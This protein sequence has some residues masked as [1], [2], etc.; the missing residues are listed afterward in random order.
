[1]KQINQHKPLIFG[2]RETLK[3]EW[4]IARGIEARRN[5]DGGVEVKIV[6]ETERDD[7]I[8]M[9]KTITAEEAERLGRALLCMEDSEFDAVIRRAM[10][11]SE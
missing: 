6:R 3:D 11:W 1:M 9:Q 7:M 5:T 2:V 4:S 10:E 8:Y